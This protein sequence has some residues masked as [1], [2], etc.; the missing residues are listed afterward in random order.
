MQDASHK[1][2]VTLCT[3]CGG[4]LL[5]WVETIHGRFCKQNKVTVKKPKY[6]G[7]WKNN[8]FSWKLSLKLTKIIPQVKYFFNCHLSDR[9]RIN[10]RISRS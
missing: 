8:Y 5:C 6:L 7:N 9:G 2:A 1:D 4:G 3:S 10:D